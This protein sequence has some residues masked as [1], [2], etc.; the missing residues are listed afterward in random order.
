MCWIVQV[1]E[2]RAVLCEYFMYKWG[3]CNVTVWY[4]NLE[5][6]LMVEKSFD[7]TSASGENEGKFV[8]T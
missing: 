4:T 2:K 3:C 5:K 6:A 1:L 7:I 8:T